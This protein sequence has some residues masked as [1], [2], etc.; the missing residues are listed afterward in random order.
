MPESSIVPVPLPKKPSFQLFGPY[1]IFGWRHLL[2]APVARGIGMIGEKADAEEF[3]KNPILFF[4]ELSNP[5]FRK[6]GRL[7]YPFD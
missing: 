6:L 5:T 2:T 3:R 4:R 7:L 1:G